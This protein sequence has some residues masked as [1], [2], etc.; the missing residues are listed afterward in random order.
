MIN[1]QMCI[2]ILRWE[3]QYIIQ[4]NIRQ[5]LFSESIIGD[6]WKADADIK[7]ILYDLV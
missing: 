4:Q 3:K 2:E 6:M 7:Y 5:S 1:F